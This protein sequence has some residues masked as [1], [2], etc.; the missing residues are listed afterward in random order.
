MSDL[1]QA[2]ILMAGWKLDITHPWIWLPGTSEVPRVLLVWVF[3][4]FS[5]LGLLLAP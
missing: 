2:L 5:V 3:G 4:P 1:I